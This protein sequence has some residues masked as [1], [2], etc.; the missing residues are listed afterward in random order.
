MADWVPEFLRTVALP[1]VPFSVTDAS[2]RYGQW[3]AAWGYQPGS[4]LLRMRRRIGAHQVQ[5]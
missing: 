5:G 2:G 3:F 4:V 1:G